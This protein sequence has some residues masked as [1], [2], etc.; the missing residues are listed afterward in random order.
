MGDPNGPTLFETLQE[1]TKKQ[2]VYLPVEL[3]RTLAT[4]VNLPGVDVSLTGLLANIVQA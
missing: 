2:N 1:A 4:V 3:H